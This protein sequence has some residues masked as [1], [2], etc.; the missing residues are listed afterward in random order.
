MFRRE[1]LDR[2]PD[3]QC[4]DDTHLLAA[5]TPSEAEQWVAQLSVIGEMVRES[6]NLDDTDQEGANCVGPKVV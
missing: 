1:S 6:N 4:G 5:P 2:Y 3:V